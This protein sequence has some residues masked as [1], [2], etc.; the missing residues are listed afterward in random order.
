MGSAIS[1]GLN[2]AVLH[3]VGRKNSVEHFFSS[4]FLPLGKESE[5]LILGLLKR[6]RLWGSVGSGTGKEREGD[7]E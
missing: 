5:A 4:V 2:A 6:G 3:C 1:T 7:S